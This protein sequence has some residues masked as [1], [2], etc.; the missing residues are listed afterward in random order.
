MLQCLGVRL[1]IEESLVGD[2]LEVLHC[3]FEQDTLSSAWYWFN[4]E[5][6]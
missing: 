1:E 2:S 4:Q 3:V 5:I 6:P